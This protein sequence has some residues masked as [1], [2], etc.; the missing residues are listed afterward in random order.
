MNRRNATHA[1][2]R[3][4]SA[5]APTALERAAYFVLLA[6][7][8]A[9][10]LIPE[11]FEHAALSFLS[12]EAQASGPKP[13]GTAWLD[14]LLLLAAGLALL[15]AWRSLRAPKAIIL[16]V[17]LLTAAAVASTT[18]ADDKRA[19]S[20]AAG[21]L[22]AVVLATLALSRVSRAPWM[23]HALLAAALAG[24]GANA[25]RCLSQWSYEFDQTYEYWLEQKQELVRRGVDADTPA[26][27]NYE[28]R[29]RSREPFGYLYHPNVAAS[30][31]VMALVAASGAAA[32]A[33]CKPAA[34]RP[35]RSSATPRWRGASVRLLALAVY[36]GLLGWAIFLTGSLGAIAAGTLS[37][38]ALLVM[39]AARRA[40]TRRPQAWFRALIGGYVLLVLVGAGYGAT[41]GTLPHTSLAFR[42]QYW[43]AAV[44]A[45][46]EAPWTGIGRGNFRDAY[47][48]HKQPQATED[49]ADPHN[50]WLAL[51][52]ELGPLGACG[53]AILVAAALASALR[54]ASGEAPSA[55]AGG[56]QAPH[57]V[58]SIVG[59][60]VV[61]AA[62]SGTPLSAP[63]VLVWWLTETILPWAVLF[64]AAA[65]GA[66][67]LCRSE[68]A[69]RCVRLGLAA[70]LLAALLHNLVDFSLLTPAG[71]ALCALL[72]AAAIGGERRAASEESAARTGR[73]GAWSGA[74]VGAMWL[75]QLWLIALPAT[76]VES[77]SAAAQDALRR[78]ADPA[79]LRAALARARDAARADAWDAE[80]PRVLGERLLAMAQAPHAPSDLQAELTSAAA[81]FASLARDRH[82]R[83]AAI[84][85]LNARC[86]EAEAETVLREDAAQAAARWA[87]V[88]ALWQDAVELN[89]TDPRLRIEAAAALARAWRRGPDPRL[90]GAALEHLDRAEAIDALRPAGDA[91]RLR[92]GELAAVNALR[93]ELTGSS[94]GLG[95]QP[96]LPE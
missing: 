56:V 92:E 74:A 38:A 33:L 69:A 64:A 48:R 94:P 91:T 51:L 40:I 77:A 16:G 90:A 19:A 59:M 53:V 55:D 14:N 29:M 6:I 31:M 46:A 71:D 5:P 4:A 68:P 32:G 23:R 7:L 84:T 73:R 28:R 67:R 22:L 47:L 79:S 2:L 11:T 21:H 78:A 39:I 12:P 89:P 96:G 13:A 15:A 24:G 3:A 60:A 95:S 49:V 83:S 88:V 65:I 35:E 45:Y 66:E 76:R 93:A 27:V 9:R 80:T 10:P 87:A 43:G 41:R 75:G 17:G 44:Q 54:R 30:C 61:H 37:L 72:V 8:A 34:R 1:E 85:R 57:I 20:F 36:L 25:L 58:M 63:G 18:V 62:A 86:A 82:P 70:A 52:T 42:W 50:L 26:I 81:A